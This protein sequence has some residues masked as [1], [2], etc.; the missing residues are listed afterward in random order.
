MA[1]LTQ[2]PRGTQDISPKES[3]KWQYIE[4]AMLETAQAFGFSEIRTPTFEHTE[5]FTRSVGDTTD[6][7]QK[8]MYTFT[9]KGE[10]SITLR[11]E[12]TAGVVRAVVQ[13][14]IVNDGFPLKTAYFVNCFRYERPKSGRL[15]EFHQFG[16]ESFGA[17]NAS[18]DA[19]IIALG[20]A[21]LERLELLD[22]ATLE[23]NS[24]GCPECR[25]NYTQELIAY[26]TDKKENL[27][28]VC[29][30][31]LQKNPLRILDCKEEVCQK[32]AQDAPSILQ[33]LCEECDTHFEQVKY[34]LD[35]MRIE[36]TVNDRVVRGLDYYTKTVFEFVTD[37]IG[38]ICG[39][40]RYDGL[41]EQLGVA[42]IPALG[43][44]IGL[45]R[46]LLIMEQHCAPVPN[47]KV[48]DIYLGNI[49]EQTDVVA[50]QLTHILR[51]EGFY[52][53]FDTIGRSVKAQ[54]K[55]ANKIG[56]KFSAIIG[57]NELETGVLQ[58]KNM[59]SG[60][61]NE[62]ALTGLVNFMFENII[63]DLEL[64]FGDLDINF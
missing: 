17:A 28:K 44:A 45:E 47:A 30:E 6:V 25:P 50:L 33:S 15:R 14:G 12:G 18:A 59:E 42:K 40:G 49:G 63:T 64:S 10:R 21:I 1:F 32:I 27:C 2:S 34:N 38:T 41:T 57:E 13:S 7:V 26:F 43:F 9:D 46:L 35:A 61:Q 22:F 60:E 29:N 52:A 36:Y 24:I 37:T 58:V 5:L 51:K 11:P 20:S 55:Y 53:E 56:A 8:E 23:I 19:E 62:V 48:C 4:R 16:V 31:R 54:M 39:G 3:H